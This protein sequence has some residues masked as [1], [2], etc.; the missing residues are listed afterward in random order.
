VCNLPNE[1][2]EVAEPLIFVPKSLANCNALLNCMAPPISA[3]VESR[4]NVILSEPLESFIVIASP[5]V[6][7]SSDLIVSSLPSS[8]ILLTL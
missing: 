3:R 2:V 4:A 6:F 7:K 8:S 1:P 5:T